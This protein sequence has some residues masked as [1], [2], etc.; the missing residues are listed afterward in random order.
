MQTG[1][2]TPEE[3][4]A[5]FPQNV[6]AMWCDDHDDY[7]LVATM[8]ANFIVNAGAPKSKAHGGPRTRTSTGT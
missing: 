5:H 8:E 3:A 2:I 6:H 4:L 1:T 7:L